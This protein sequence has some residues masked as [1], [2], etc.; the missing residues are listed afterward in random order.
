MDGFRLHNP[1]DP[2]ERAGSVPL[3]VNLGNF[4]IQIA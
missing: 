2:V 3:P 1:G 4:V